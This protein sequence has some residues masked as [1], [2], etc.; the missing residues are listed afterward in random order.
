MILIGNNASY[1]I[2]IPAA[3]IQLQPNNCADFMRFFLLLNGAKHA[4][5]IKSVDITLTHIRYVI[6]IVIVVPLNDFSI[7]FVASYQPSDKLFQQVLRFI[8]FSIIS[9][10]FL[11]LPFDGIFSTRFVDMWMPKYGIR[12]N[13][14]S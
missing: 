9:F 8:F 10:F 3:P 14:H 2:E 7:E 5:A 4:I 12:M 6:A 1:Y 11:T 13:I